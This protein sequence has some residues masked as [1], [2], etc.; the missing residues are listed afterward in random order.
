MQMLRII[1]YI[2]ALFC[3][4]AITVIYNPSHFSSDDRSLT[5]T[6]LAQRGSSLMGKCACTTTC[7]VTWTCRISAHSTHVRTTWWRACDT[8]SPVSCQQWLG[9]PS[10]WCRFFDVFW[11]VPIPD[12]ETN[13]V[14]LE[15]EVDTA[16]NI[17]YVKFSRLLV[18]SDG[19]DERLNRPLYLFF[20]FG[21]FYPSSNFFSPINDPGNNI[22]LSTSPLQFDCA[23]NRKNTPHSYVIA[24]YALCHVTL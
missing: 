23:I 9:C 8:S 16:T 2:C 3:Q 20:S 17:A 7:S 11:I 6:L 5:C 15:R 18:T 10:L 1:M 4:P 19:S 21:P 24:L 22:W 12:D 14:L 13:A